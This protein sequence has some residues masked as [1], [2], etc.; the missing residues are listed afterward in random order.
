MKN[1]ELNRE[2][3]KR[4]RELRKSFG[5]TRDTLAEL[6]DVSVAHMGLL[7]RGE[8]GT[9]IAK[10]ILLSEILAVPVEYIIT[11]RNGI[12]EN[13]HSLP[14]AANKFT[15][16]ELHLLNEFVKTYSL[17]PPAKR[18]PDIIF[19]GIRFVLSQYVKT[20]QTG[21]TE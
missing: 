21:I 11:G 13:P 4:I 3:G 16:Y 17:V 19:E 5:I 2:I 6:L 7:E 9:S 20:V 12:A 18:N 8:R 1:Q 10:C 14:A 15:R